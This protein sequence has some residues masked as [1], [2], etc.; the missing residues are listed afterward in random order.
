MSWYALAAVLAG[1][2]LVQVAAGFAR[3]WWRAKTMG[4]R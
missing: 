1:W 4:V 2:A 3:A